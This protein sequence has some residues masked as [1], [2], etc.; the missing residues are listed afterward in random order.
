MIHDQAITSG[1][2]GAEI[3]RIHKMTA[4]L[5]QGEL[6]RKLFHVR[7]GLKKLELINMLIQSL[8]PEAKAKARS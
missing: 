5:L 1:L 8:G 7:T 4:P 6:I 3:Y 2:S